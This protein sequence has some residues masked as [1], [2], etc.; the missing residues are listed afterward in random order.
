M[1]TTLV[2]GATGFV[3]SAVVRHLLDAHH[4]VRVMVRP[5]SALANIQGLE[6]EVAQGDLTRP[7]T[8]KSAI[9]GCDTLF[10]VAADYR[11]WAPDR[12]VLYRTNVAGTTALLRAAADEGVSKIVYTSSVAVLGLNRDGTPSDEGTPSNLADMIGHYKR[13]KYLAEQAVHR[14]IEEDKLPV[15]IVN[16]STPI[17]PRDIKP[18]P[19]GR[20]V[21][22]AASGRMPAY[23][24]TGLN[25]VHV[26]DVAT[27]H[28]LALA[29][30]EI[31]ERYI[32]GG[33]N[34]TLREILAVISEITERPAPKIRLPHNLVLPVAYLGEMWAR[35]TRGAEPRATVDGVRMSKKRMYF[36]SDKAGRA[37]GYSPR[38]AREAL[39]D[40]VNWFLNSD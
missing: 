13:S 27:G 1:M 23:V 25:V 34:M 7:E 32:L 35:L 19:T 9:S 39:E 28:L 22:D 31:G 16:P 3:G 14:M 17:G 6:V 8:L 24:D 36:N 38:P 4:N 26:D 40:A 11:L 15:T 33:E 12:D 21:L 30:G 29:Q 18:T 5:Q 20:M 2:T 37:L 10:H